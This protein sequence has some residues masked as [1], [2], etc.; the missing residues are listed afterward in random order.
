MVRYMVPSYPVVIGLEAGQSAFGDTY[1]WFRSLLSWPLQNTLIQSATIDA[2]KAKFLLDE[3]IDKMLSELGRQAEQVS[4]GEGSE[5]A[6]DWLNG[7]RTPDANQLLKGAIQGLNLRSDAPRIYRALVE[8]TCFGAKKIVDCFID[9][10]IPIEGLIG[11]GGV[12]KKS[13][14]IMQMMADILG[15]PIKVHRSAQTCALGAAMFAATVAGMYPN[16]KEAMA[17]MRNGFEREYQP[18]RQKA[19][20]NAIRYKR[21]MDLSRFIEKETLNS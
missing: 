6:V 5:L 1:A 21:Y 8:G 15:M 17:A 16:V 7:R 4:L 14:F 2:D 19:E 9:H 18:N 10:G 11:L 12:A 20:L 13:P 3:T